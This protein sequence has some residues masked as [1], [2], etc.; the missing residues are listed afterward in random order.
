MDRSEVT[1]LT[2]IDLSRCFDTVD[3]KMLITKLQQLQISTGW[4]QS[5]LEEHTQRVRIGQTLSSPK[6]ITIGTVSGF[7]SRNTALHVR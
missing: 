3:P 1:L 5:Y 2:L 4:I 6:N 7:L